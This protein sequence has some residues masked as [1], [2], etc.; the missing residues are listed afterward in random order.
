VSWAAVQ[1]FGKSGYQSA[2]VEGDAYRRARLH[3]TGAETG[4]TV[5]AR[6]EQ[7]LVSPKTREH[8]SL[9]APKK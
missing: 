6:D 3:Q 8:D 1:L 2:V 4:A 5:A 7:G 9:L